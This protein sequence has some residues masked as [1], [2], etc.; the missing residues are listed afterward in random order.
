MGRINCSDQSETS[1]PPLPVAAVISFLFLIFDL[2]SSVSSSTPKRDKRDARASSILYDKFA[3]QNERDTMLKTKEIMN[4][5][6]PKHSGHTQK[7]SLCEIFLFTTYF[8]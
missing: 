2:G 8:I 4:I 6:Y 5:S 7:N 3:T 1:L